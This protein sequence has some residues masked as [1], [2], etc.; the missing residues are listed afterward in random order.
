MS[1]INNEMTNSQREIFQVIDEWWKNHGYGPSIDEIMLITGE[2]GRGNVSRKIQA[3]VDLGVL[4]KV[5]R[6]ARSVRPRGMRV[7]KL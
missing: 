1:L 4:I 5:G 7:Y 2:K 6:R 3:L